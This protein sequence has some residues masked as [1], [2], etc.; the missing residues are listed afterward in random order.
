MFSTLA[1]GENEIKSMDLD[2]K[3]KKE[4]LTEILQSFSWPLR[5]GI[6][7]IS[8]E[9][10]RTT[11]RFPIGLG[12]Q[13][14]WMVRLTFTMHKTRFKS[15][16][17]VF[18]KNS[19]V[20]KFKNSLFCVFTWIGKTHVFEIADVRSWTSTCLLQC[21]ECAGTPFLMAAVILLSEISNL[22]CL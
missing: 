15:L 12:C 8:Y 3:E 18:S 10:S 21:Y 14:A 19:N 11:G 20:Q 16:K 13:L 1:H 6:Q 17:D 22:T 5:S 9:L 4:E 7:E 2:H